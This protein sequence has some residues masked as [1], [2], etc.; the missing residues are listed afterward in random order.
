MLEIRLTGAATAVAEKIRWAL[1]ETLLPV[2]R[3]ME[4]LG[5]LGAFADRQVLDFQHLEIPVLQLVDTAAA[6][7]IPQVHDALIGFGERTVG[8]PPT[9]SAKQW[10]R[11]LQRAL[12]EGSSSFSRGP[13]STFLASC[14]HRKQS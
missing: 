10:K 9:T 8:K 4:G 13:P 12:Q 5:V 3:K 2:E 7:A 14:P 11:Q 6:A 1:A